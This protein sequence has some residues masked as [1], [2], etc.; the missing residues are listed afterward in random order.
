MANPGISIFSKKVIRTKTENSVEV[1]FFVPS[2][3][4]LC[5]FKFKLIADQ[6]FKLLFFLIGIHSMQGGTATTRH[7]VTRKKS[8][9]KITGYRKC[10]WKEPT[11][12]RY[13]LL[14][15]LKPLRS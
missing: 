5:L 3:I 11:V 4:E 7:G 6:L 10:V 15:D 9:T 1:G 8:T 2:L 13:L 12:K 14:L